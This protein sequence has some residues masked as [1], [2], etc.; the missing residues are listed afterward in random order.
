[1]FLRGKPELLKNMSGGKRQKDGK[2]PSSTPRKPRKSN[3]SAKRSGNT[4]AQDASSGGPAAL[5]P[6]GVGA[7]DLRNQAL[8]SMGVGGAVMGGMLNPGRGD[9]VFLP[10][11]ALGMGMNPL[12]QDLRLQSF[13]MAQQNANLLRQQQARVMAE[14]AASEQ[15]ANIANELRLRRFAG[16]PSDSGLSSRMLL[17]AAAQQPA[18]PG[19]PVSLSS[20]GYMG[21]PGSLGQQIDPELLQLIIERERQRQQQG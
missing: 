14:I 2:S 16:G 3:A 19:I 7:M 11:T 20:Q 12:D 4:P 5:F 1:M 18:A 9:D 8:A 10:Q 13:L 21:L 6:G 15:Q 17:A